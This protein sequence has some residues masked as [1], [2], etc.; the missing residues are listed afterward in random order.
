MNEHRPYVSPLSEQELYDLWMDLKLKWPVLYERYSNPDYSRPDYDEE[1]RSAHGGVASFVR[2]RF[3]D[4]NF[5]PEQMDILSDMINFH[6]RY[7]GKSGLG[8][9]AQ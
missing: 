9:G 5:Y 1:L 7:L 8:W 6:G 3:P 4:V 2:Q